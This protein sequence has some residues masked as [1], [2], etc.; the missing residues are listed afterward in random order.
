MRLDTPLQASARGIRRFLLEAVDL[1]SP[2]RYQVAAEA[3]PDQVRQEIRRLEAV[4]LDPVAAVE[5]N[6]HL[7]LA[8][9]IPGYTSALLEGLLSRGQ[10]RSSSTRDMPRVCFPSTTAIIPLT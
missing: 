8:A 10:A 5:C 7:V 9:R 1:L 2:H 3:P 4:Q 6:Q